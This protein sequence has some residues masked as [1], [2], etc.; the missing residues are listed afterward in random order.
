ME[1]FE[2]P[3]DLDEVVPNLLLAKYLVTLLLLVNQLEHVAAIRVL[4]HEAETVGCVLKE[5][6]LVANHVGV[7]DRSENADLIEC[8]LFFFATEFLQFYFFHCVSLIVRLA[9]NQIHFAERPF[10]C[11]LHGSHLPSFF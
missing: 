5:G 11:R 9:Q 1:S 6:L 7:T 2:A 8:I 4:H 3:D 10:A